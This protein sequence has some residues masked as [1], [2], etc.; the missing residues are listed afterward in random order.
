MENIEIATRLEELADLLEIK[1]SNPFRIRAYRNAIR[2]IRGLTRPL[3]E[4]VANGE[5][6]EELPGIG[7][8]LSGQIHELLATG[9]MELLEEVAKEVPRELAA[10]TKIEGVGPK[11]AKKLWKELGV[12]SVDRLEAAVR[13]GRVAGLE[14]FGGKSAEK[15]LQAIEGFRKH[16]GRFLRGE[17]GELLR[18]LLDH[19]EKAN[20]VTRLDCQLLRL[21]ARLWQ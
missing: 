12:T 5:D 10:L 17:A 20:G 19:M 21:A 16:Q 11:K 14:G 4:M 15:I 9:G 13:D 2:L 1:G 3:S 18:P 6:L 7:E 8:D